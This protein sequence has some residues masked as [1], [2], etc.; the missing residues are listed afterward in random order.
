M[1]RLA[2]KTKSPTNI[3]CFFFKPPLF[4][5][6]NT[7]WL[8]CSLKRLYCL[9]MTCINRVRRTPRCSSGTP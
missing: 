2:K 9:I 4:Y 1:S 8:S 3:R 6:I 5:T 7:Q